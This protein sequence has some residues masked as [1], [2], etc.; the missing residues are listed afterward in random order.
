MKKKRG[1]TKRGRGIRT[2]YRKKAI[3]REGAYNRSHLG[4]RFDVEMTKEGGEM[5][6]AN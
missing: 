4:P 1:L 2:P 6:S 3:V 5:S